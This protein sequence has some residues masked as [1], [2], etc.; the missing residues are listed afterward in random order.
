MLA[1]ARLYF[2][3]MQILLCAVLAICGFS[4]SLYAQESEQPIK[5]TL[6]D[7]KKDPLAFNKKLVEVSG[8]G[9]FGFE[10]SMFEDPTCFKGAG[11]PGIWME[12][13]GTAS[14]D[15]MYCCGVSAS[16]TKKPLIVQDIPVPLI[17]DEQFKRF[18]TLLHS[19]NPNKDISVHAV[20]RGRIFV[21]PSTTAQLHFWGYGHMGCCMLLAVE[22]VLSVDSKKAGPSIFDLAKKYET[23]KK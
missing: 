14:T 8:Y 19:K 1:T 3:I 10:D 9:T 20:V 18:D 12:Y 23:Q 2:R 16:N 17:A 15:T 22:Q 6:C 4:T 11:R 7:I 5:T 21:M 13:G